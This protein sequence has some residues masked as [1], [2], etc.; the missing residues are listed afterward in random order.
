MILG[1]PCGNSLFLLPPRLPLSLSLSLRN[2]HSWSLDP[3]GVPNLC[4]PNSSPP[5]PRKERASTEASPACP[6]QVR[7]ALS[8]SPDWAAAG[9]CHM[10]HN[11][12]ASGNGDMAHPGRSHP[13]RDLPV[14]RVTIGCD[15]G[16]GSFRCLVTGMTALQRSSFTSVDLGGSL[17]GAVG[18]RASAW[19]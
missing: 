4:F 8:G 9:E 13:E 17:L 11:A 16:K 2:F 18:V 15:V 19:C 14:F 6:F 12:I 3:T 1:A 10:L 7:G 5:S